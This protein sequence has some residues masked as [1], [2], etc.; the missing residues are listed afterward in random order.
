MGCRDVIDPL[1][2]KVSSKMTE[3]GQS[4]FPSIRLVHFRRI[5]HLLCRDLVPVGELTVEYLCLGLRSNLR[6]T[7]R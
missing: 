7:S 2:E 1:T 5:L 6:V 3:K 4:V